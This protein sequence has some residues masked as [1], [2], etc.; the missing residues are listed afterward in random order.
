MAKYKMSAK[1]P[2]DLRN[3]KVFTG[4]ELLSAAKRLLNRLDLTTAYLMDLERYAKAGRM[5]DVVRVGQ[6]IKNNMELLDQFRGEEP[7]Q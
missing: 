4:P 3:H 1:L 6:E 5:I 2:K 7:K